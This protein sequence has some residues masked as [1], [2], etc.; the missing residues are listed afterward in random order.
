MQFQLNKSSVAV[1]LASM[2]LAGTAGAGMVGASFSSVG[3]VHSNTDPQA[4]ASF[5]GSI[6]WSYTSGS[7]ARV[8]VTIR[9]TSS[10]GYLTA[11]G[12]DLANDNFSTRQTDGPDSF[13]GAAGGDLGFGGFGT[14]RFG[15]VWAEDFTGDGHG[16]KERGIGAGDTGTWTFRVRGTAS[17]L[18][19]VTSAAA[20]DG[21]NAW[22]FAARFEGI[23]SYNWDDDDK[24]NGDGGTDIVASNVP[25]PGALSLLGAAAL[26]GGR[27]RRR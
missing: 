8:S 9:N 4:Q 20:F 1:S 25:A 13:E 23:D 26:V 10:S 21:A 27:R 17:Q 3:A 6:E 11:I 19:A 16:S 7:F 14:F 24:G 18:A 2:L 12:F 15:S 5:D 22:D